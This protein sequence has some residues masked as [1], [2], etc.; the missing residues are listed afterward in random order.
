[1]RYLITRAKRTAFERTT[2]GD[3]I[4]LAFYFSARSSNIMDKSTLGLFQALMHQLILQCPP[5]P[6]AILEIFTERNEVRSD[7]TWS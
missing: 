4:V 5:V 1:M 6:N 3:A 2:S 7:W